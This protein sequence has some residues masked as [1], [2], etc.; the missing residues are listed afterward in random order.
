MRFG[1]SLAHL[2]MLDAT[3]PQLVAA[4]AAAGFTGVG[5]RLAPAR[6]GER[7]FP[8]QIGSPMLGET[9]ARLRDTGVKV[10]EVE[11]IRIRPGF[12][13]RALGP[14]LDSAQALGAQ[15]LMVNVDDVDTGRAAQALGQVAEAAARHG[16]AVCIEFMVYTAAR[17]LAQASALVAQCGHAG[18]RVIVDALHFF[19][20][21]HVPQD[22]GAWPVARDFAQLN[23]A[24]AR[25]HPGLSAAEE[26]RA[27]RL[28]PGE[29]ELALAQLLQQLND[30][31]TL[32]V[33]APSAIRTAT[34]AVPARA[35][36]AWRTT[37][38]FLERCGHVSC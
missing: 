4:A 11:I 30:G 12:D 19:R 14:V 7:P 31:A 18:V 32:S 37:H 34:L 21:G 17:N 2:G 26:G 29:G 33:E 15:R 16:I 1:L 20:A 3:P 38:D 5:L 9:T 23:D 24:P 27:H 10:C 13:A 25:R 8:M 36:L 35:A 22:I 28:L 6:P